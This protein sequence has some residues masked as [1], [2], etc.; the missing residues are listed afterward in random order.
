[1]SLVNFAKDGISMTCLGISMTLISLSKVQFCQ[2][3]RFDEFCGIAT[4]SY[5][6]S[7][8]YSVTLAGLCSVSFFMK[9]FLRGFD[10]LFCKFLHDGS[11]SLFVSFV[12]SFET[13]CSPGLANIAFT[14][15]SSALVTYLGSHFLRN[16]WLS[17]FEVF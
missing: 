7:F 16:Q 14:T 10:D 13:S 9:L 11:A 3:C 12:I 6:V 2:N 15:T 1:M 5:F 8:V 17:I 4:T